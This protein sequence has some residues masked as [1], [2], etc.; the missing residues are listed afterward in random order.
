M[1]FLSIKHSVSIVTALLLIAFSS[2]SMAHPQLQKSVPTADAVL[3]GAPK[4]IR[5]EF[6]EKLEAAFS[7]ISISGLPGRKIATEKAVVDTRDGKVMTLALPALQPGQY[8]VN[9]NAVTVDGHHVKSS[10]KF[11]IAK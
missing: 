9:W 1:K 4:N 5:I 2:V 7:T 3:K 6:N 8:Q 10:Y 11:S